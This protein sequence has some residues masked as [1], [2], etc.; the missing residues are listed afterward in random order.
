[1]DFYNN[2]NKWK[3]LLAIVGATIVLITMIYSQFLAG[4]L[5]DREESLVEFY[6]PLLNDL[7]GESLDVNTSEEKDL[8]TELEIVETV[9]SI[10]P[11]IL[12]DETGSLIGF[13]YN[14]EGDV[15]M[16][17]VFLEKRKQA[18]LDKGFKPMEGFGSSHRIYYENSKLF[19]QVSWFP[20][21]QVLLLGTFVVFG[22]FVFSSS[23]KAEQNRVWAGM[24]KETAHQ[25]GT[26]LSS[27]LGWISILKMENVDETYIVEI[28]KDVHRLNTIANR[29]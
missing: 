20:L 16:D 12:E 1:M 22:Y 6:A 24:A 7:S 23:R 2:N 5:A 8:T 4:K 18:L 28:E 26:P 13:N 10:V 9:G 11:T 21:A 15:T 27:L 29:C 14:E 17:Q 25:I 19:H 3:I